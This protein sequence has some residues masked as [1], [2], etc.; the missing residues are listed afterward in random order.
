MSGRNRRSGAVVKR[1]L[2]VAALALAVGSSHGA[3]S[4]STANPAPSRDFDFLVGDWHVHHRYLR[5]VAGRTEWTQAEGAVSH[6][7][8]LGGW[9]NIDDTVL[10]PASG[11]YRALA[12]RSCDT[13]AG[14]WA[15]WWLDGRD[16]SGALD[17]AAKGRFENGTG[18]FFG[19]TTFDGK[20]VPKRFIW[21][22]ITLRSAQWE[23]A[24]SFDCGKTWETNWIMEFS[25]PPRAAGP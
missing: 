13:K 22:K 17:P 15:I 25:R 1:V 3:P 21:S 20:P 10:N 19:E 8:I 11:S 6:R 2:A 16:P 23:Q 7:H 5:V 4:S 14:Q 24:Y 9:A 12:L 18:T